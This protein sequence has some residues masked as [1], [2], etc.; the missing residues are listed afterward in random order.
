MMFSYLSLFLGLLSAGSLVAPR[1]QSLARANPITTAPLY[2]SASGVP[3]AKNTTGEV[4]VENGA[5]VVT[6][7][8]SHSAAITTLH[9]QNL[10]APTAVRIG[11]ELPVGTIKPKGSAVFAV[12][13]GW[14]GRVAVQEVGYEI[15]DRVS[16]FEGSFMVQY[17][18]EARIA[19]D[20]S[21]VDGFSLPIVCSCR[22]AVVLGCNLDLH[23]MCPDEHRLDNKTCSNPWRDDM[24]APDPSSNFFSDCSPMA[25]TFPTDDKATI[26]G[27]LGCEERISCCIGTACPAHPDQ[28]LCPGKDGR[29]VP[30]HK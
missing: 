8:N 13:T 11:G 7:V 23:Q 19:L 14:A 26:N 27:I 25:Y 2:P 29:A 10:N 4:L 16:L 6:L 24:G 15:T 5:Y 9:A 1:G 22:N 3:R 17:G 18:E 21:Y 30:C 20:V 12:P 28:E